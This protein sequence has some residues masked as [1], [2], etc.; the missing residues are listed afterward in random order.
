M[1]FKQ[2]NLYGLLFF[3]LLFFCSKLVI[4]VDLICNTMK[5][6]CMTSN[7]VIKLLI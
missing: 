3:L 7:T 6:N 1:R 5:K 4:E 2:P